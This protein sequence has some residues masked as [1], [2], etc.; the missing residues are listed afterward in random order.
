M[1]RAAVFQMAL[2][3][4]AQEAEIS[5]ISA[6]GLAQR[7]ERALTSLCPGTLPSKEQ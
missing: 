4:A 3:A 7:D 6:I 5:A 2:K 1:K